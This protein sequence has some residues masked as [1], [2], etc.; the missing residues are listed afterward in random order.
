MTAW[1]DGAYTACP[2]CGRTIG[3][4]NFA[5]HTRNCVFRPEQ[6]AALRLVLDYGDGSIKVREHYAATRG[7]CLSGNTILRQLD[8]ESWEVVAAHFGLRF[9]RDMRPWKHLIP[10]KAKQE[11]ATT[12]APE[13]VTVCGLPVTKKGCQERVYLAERRVRQPDGMYLEVRRVVEERYVLR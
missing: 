12:V 6:I 7:E 2:H 8:T 1:S 5:K 3:N 10:P 4:T 9:V 11:P 13:A